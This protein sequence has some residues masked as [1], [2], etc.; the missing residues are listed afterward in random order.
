MQREVIIRLLVD[1]RS[2]DDRLARQVESVWEGGTAR[3]ALAEGLKLNHD[4]S[5]LSVQVERR[6]SRRPER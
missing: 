6:K 4:P 1:S 5:L 2:D 3:E